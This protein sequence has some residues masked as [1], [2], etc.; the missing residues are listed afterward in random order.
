MNQ[1]LKV[2]KLEANLK[3][4]YLKNSKKLLFHGWHHINYVRNKAIEFGKPIKADL[5]IVE[6]AAL[7]HDLNYLV[8]LF[9]KARDGKALREK[10]LFQAGYFEEEVVQIEK[11]ILESETAF[12]GR[13]ISTEGKAL[14]DADASF[15]CLP[16]TPIL[17]TSKY[18]AENKVDLKTSATK[19]VKEQKALL[20]KGIFFYTKLAKKRYLKYEK[21]Q[22]VMWEGVL[23]V[24]EDKDVK[25]ML[26][27]AKK[28]GVL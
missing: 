25:E 21:A 22:I 26:A 12:R 4:L 27:E 2:Q 24:L 14:S 13:K 17:F 20:Q 9:S 8:K 5:F 10:Y 16:T 6:S 23:E 15:K 3:K 1:K 28:L 7:T 19:I 18:L 11:V